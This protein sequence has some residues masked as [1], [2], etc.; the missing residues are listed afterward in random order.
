MKK[1]ANPPN[2]FLSAQRELLESEPATDAKLEIYE[3]ASRTLLSKNESPDLSFTWSVNPYRGCFHSCAY[4]YARR[5]H[6][7]L[8]MGAG[9]DFESK[10]VIKPEAP[11]LLR[12]AFMKPSWQGETVMFSGVTDCFQP[13]EAVYKLTQGCLKVCVDFKNPA[14]FIT[15]SFLI[16][17]D[18][19]LLAELSRVAYSPRSRSASRFRRTSWRAK[20]SQCKPPPSIAGFKRS[21]LSPKPACRSVCRS[22]RRSRASTKTTSRLFSSARRTAARVTRSIRWC[23]SRAACG[24]CSK[25]KSRRLCRP[26]ASTGSH[27]ASQRNPSGKMNDSRFGHRHHGEGTYWKSIFGRVSAH[28]SQIR[29]S[30]MTIQTRHFP[31]T[32]RRPGARRWRCL[33]FCRLRFA[34]ML[35]AT[36]SYKVKKAFMS[37]SILI[38]RCMSTQHPDN[39]NAPFFSQTAQLTGDEEVREAFHVYSALGCDEQ[40]WDHEGKEVDVHVVPKLLSQNS[41]FFPQRNSRQKCF[42]HVARVTCPIRRANG[43]SAKRPARNTGKHSTLLRRRAPILQPLRRLSHP[44]SRLS[45]R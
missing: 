42:P 12:E 16:T 15:K 14:G 38:P 13:I 39:A 45:C 3:D 28:P 11:A 34:S 29:R 37:D 10:L 6:E 31:S 18:T 22:R 7:Y 26:N 5:Y 19:E 43:S 24:R 2:P 25:R 23:A 1:I 9:T 44:F 20:S 4:C 40:M 30:S 35:S 36:P 8:D 41:A 17:R 33:S 27:Q 21:R 32:F